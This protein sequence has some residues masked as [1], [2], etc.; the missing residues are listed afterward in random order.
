MDLLERS[1][2]GV[3]IGGVSLNDK[4]PD[5]IRNRAQRFSTAAHDR[6]VGAIGHKAARDSGANPGSATGDESGFS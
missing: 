3:R 4:A 1:A 5:V 2:H 6:H